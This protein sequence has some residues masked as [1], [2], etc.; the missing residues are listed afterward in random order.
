MASLPDRSFFQP[1][2]SISPPEISTYSLEILALK[3]KRL[4]L[5]LEI[6][7]KKVGAPSEERW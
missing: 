5:N 2:D 1:D 4:C 3:T 7:M 6:S